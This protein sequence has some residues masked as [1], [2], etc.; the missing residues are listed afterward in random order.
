MDLSD[1]VPRRLREPLRL[2]GVDRLDLDLDLR[3]VREGPH[4]RAALVRHRE[5]EGE[6]A[7]GQPE[8]GGVGVQH[9]GDGVLEKKHR[10]LLLCISHILLYSILPV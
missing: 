2:V 1:L 4:R 10:E 9:A 3:H 7:A 8:E 5:G 6:A